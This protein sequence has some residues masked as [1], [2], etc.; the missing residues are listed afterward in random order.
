LFE[1][2]GRFWNTLF[3]GIV[4]TGLSA[5]PVLL[6]RLVPL[7]TALGNLFAPLAGVLLFHYVF[8]ERMKIDV[9]ALFD[10]KGVYHYWHGVNVTAIV[11]CCVGGGFYYLLPIAAVPAVIT[12]VVTGA[13]YLLTVRL[14]DRRPAESFSLQ[15]SSL[16][17]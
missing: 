7:T 17:E 16:G 8:V 13:G 14:L 5:L 12:P 2:P 10:P 15:A 9:P 11:W 4:S 6:E 1:G 3:V